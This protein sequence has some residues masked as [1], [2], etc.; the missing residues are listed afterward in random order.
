MKAIT[1]LLKAKN[2]N[3]GESHTVTKVTTLAGADAGDEGLSKFINACREDP[4]FGDYKIVPLGEECIMVAVDYNYDG[5]MQELLQY[6]DG[7]VRADLES[8]HLRG[9]NV[10]AG[11]LE[12]VFEDGKLC[13]RYEACST[14]MGMYMHHTDPVPRIEER[15]IQYALKVL[16]SVTHPKQT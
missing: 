7:L 3:I 4:H 13:Y 11:S 9:S 6:A 10:K 1:A 14:M 12:L 5:S 16:P 2:F 8:G 15:V